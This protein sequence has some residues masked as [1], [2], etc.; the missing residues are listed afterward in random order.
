VTHTSYYASFV[1]DITGCDKIKETLRNWEMEFVCVGYTERNSVGNSEC[2]SSVCLYSAVLLSVRQWL[3][4]LRVRVKKSE[5]GTF[6]R[7]LKR[8]DRRCTFGWRICHKNCQI[9]RCIESDSFWGYVSIHESW[10]DIISEEEQ[11]AKIDVDRKRLLYTGKKLIRKVTELQ[12]RWQGSIIEYS[13]WRPCFH[14]HCQ[15]WASQIQ[16]PR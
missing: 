12:H 3:C 11:L 1:T 9:I 4:W 16:H 10:E 15:T 13:S 5:T 14:K 2:S 8:T 7:F 6:V